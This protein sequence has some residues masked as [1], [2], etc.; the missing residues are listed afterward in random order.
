MKYFNNVRTI[1]P[2]SNLSQNIQIFNLFLTIFSPV[3]DGLQVND[4]EEERFLF[5]EPLSPPG[6]Q[7]K[8]PM[9]L[10]ITGLP[11]H[12]SYSSGQTTPSPCSIPQYSPNTKLQKHNLYQVFRSGYRWF[13]LTTSFYQTIISTPQVRLPMVPLPLR[14]RSGYP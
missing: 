11:N 6:P 5:S 8:L 12:Q 3:R 10:C 9:V 14:L 4:L 1:H 2:L 7:V 13:S